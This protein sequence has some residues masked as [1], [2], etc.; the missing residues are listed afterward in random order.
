MDKSFLFFIFVAFFVASLQGMN[1]AMTVDNKRIVWTVVLEHGRQWFS[2]DMICSLAVSK[3]HDEILRKT[4]QERKNYLIELMSPK[5]E[6]SKSCRL[7]LEANCWH[8]YGTA[9]GRGPTITSLM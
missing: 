3:R 4:A 7:V 6:L 2:H 8:K 9:C 5:L 1:D